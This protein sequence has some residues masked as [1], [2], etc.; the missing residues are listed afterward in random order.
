[1]YH[2]I[3]HDND[4]SIYNKLSSILDS[5]LSDTYKNI[6]DLQIIDKHTSVIGLY[7]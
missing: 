1:M 3:D 6:V 4:F 2:N 5:A 7:R